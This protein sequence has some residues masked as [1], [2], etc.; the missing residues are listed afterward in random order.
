M[1]TRRT[2]GILAAAIAAFACA[3]PRTASADGHIRSIQVYQDTDTVQRQ[4][5]NTSAP[6]VA[7]DRIKIKIRLVNY[8]LDAVT[9][10]RMN[11]PETDPD[12]IDPASRMWALQHVRYGDP[13]ADTNNM[14][15]VGLWISGQCKYADIESWTLA[16]KYFTDLVCT[17]TVKAGDLAMPLKL[18]R[19]DGLADAMAPSSDA[20]P[21]AASYYGKNFDVWNF[22]PANAEGD[23]RS[24]RVD[25][26]QFYFGPQTLTVPAYA[27]EVRTADQQNQA[28]RDYDL[29][30]AGVYVQGVDF[31]DTT[32]ED[33][34]IWRNVAAGSTSTAPSPPRITIPGGNVDAQYLYVWTKDPTKVEMET[35]ENYLFGDG[36]TRRVTQLLVSP[37]QTDARFA[38]RGL[39]EDAETDIYMAATP[40]NV[41]KAADTLVTNFTWRTIHVSK[42]L[43][44]GIAVTINPDEV[45]AT[46]DYRTPVSAINVSLTQAWTNDEDLVV[47]LKP[48]MADEEART[49]GVDPFDYIGVSTASSGKEGYTKR[50]LEVTIPKGFSSSA[51]NGSVLYIYANRADAY[52]LRGIRFSVDMDATEAKTPG[53]R[54]FFTGTISD[55]TIQIDFGNPGE[56]ALSVISPEDSFEYGH[57]PGNVEFPFTIKIKDAIGELNTPGNY[58]VYWDNT[59]SGSFVPVSNLTAVVRNEYGEL[60]VMRRYVV[61]TASGN[62]Y[63]SKFYVVNSGGA[64]SATRTVLVNVD[65]PKMISYSCD[66]AD[67]IYAEGDTAQISF[68][69]SSPFEENNG[70][71]GYLFIYP[72]D[73]ATSNKVEIT[74][75]NA[76][77]HQTSLTIQPGDTNAL[78]S[79]SI[80]LKDGYAGCTLSFGVEVR[81]SNDNTVDNVISA[82]TGRPVFI[83]VTNALPRATQITM[84]GTAPKIGA[85]GTRTF[86]ASVPSG[87]QRTFKVGIADPGLRYYDFTNDTAYTELTFR[88]NGEVTATHHIYGSP[89]STNILHTFEGSGVCTVTAKVRDK[90]MT[91]DEFDAA[92]EYVANVVVVDAP[93]ISVSPA[94]GDTTFREKSG[95]G[96]INGRINV[97]LNVAPSG[98]PAGSNIT[99]VVEITPNGTFAGALPEI[100][101]SELTFTRSK[102]SDYF[103]FNSLDGT[104]GSE[105]QG[106]HIRAYVKDEAP[107]TIDPTKTWREFYAE[108]MLDVFV[109]NE[110]PKIGPGDS[111]STNEMPA[112]INVPFDIIWQVSDVKADMTNMVV[113]WITDSTT[114]RKENQNVNGTFRRTVQ[115]S[116]AGSHKVTLTVQDKDGGIDMRTWYYYVEPSMGLELR[117][118]NPLASGISDFSKRYTGAVGHGA[119]RVWSTGAANP[120]KIQNFTQSWDFKPANDLEPSIFGFGYKVGDVDNG[121]LGPAGSKDFAI[122]RAGTWYS[123]ASSYPNHYEYVNA[124]GK[125]SFF[126]TWL[127]YNREDRS[128][129]HLSAPDP[130][131][132]NSLG[133][134]RVVMPEYEDDAKSY[135]KTLVEAIFSVER[136]PEDNVGDINQ[137]GIPDIYA[138]GTTWAGGSGASRFFAVIENGDLES[139]GDLVDLSAYNGDE[140]YMPAR[141][142]HGGL[143]ISTEQNWAT[144]GGIFDAYVE[145]RGLHEG[146]NLRADND[147]L[148][149]HVR[150]KWISD[151][152]F[153]EAESNAIARVNNLWVVETDDDGNETRRLPSPTNAT[154]MAAWKAGLEKADSWIPENRTD[155]TVD[156]TDKDG[157]PDGYE[158]Y[159]WYSAMVGEDGLDKRLRGSKF[160]LDD[161]A[162]GVEITPEEIAE[163]FDP[164]KKSGVRYNERDTDDDGLL[165]I[166]ELALCTNPINWD[167]DGDGL[168]DLW[169]VMN[170]MN[171]VKSDNANNASM[172]ADGDFMAYY[173]TPADYMIVKIEGLGEY[174]I[175]NNGGNYVTTDDSGKHVFPEG[176]SNITAIA[177]FRYGKP[178]AVCVP[179]FRGGDGAKPL[180]ATVIAL[181]EHTN[182]LSAAADK[183]LALIHDQVYTQLGFDPRTAWYIDRDGFL[184]NRWHPNS[185]AGASLLNGAGDPVNTR[186]FTAMDEYLLLKYRYEATPAMPGYDPDTGGTFTFSVAADKDLW[187]DKKQDRV[188]R[189]GTTNPNVPFSDPGWVTEAMEGRTFANEAHGADTDGDGVP[190]GWELYVLHNPNDPR[191]VSNADSDSDDLNLIGEYAGTDSCNAYSGCESIANNHPGKN[192]GWYNKFF[193]TDPHDS[194][195]DGD[196]LA[197]GEE[198]GGW[199][200]TWRYG[201]SM[202]VSPYDFTF[203][204]GSNNGKPAED[205]D[206]GVDLCIRGGGL[207]PNTADTDGDLLPDKWERQ[208]AGIVFNESAQPVN[209]TV[210]DEALTLIRRSDGVAIDAT[211]E[212]TV[213]GYYI[214]AGMDGTFAGDAFTMLPD[215]DISVR[216]AFFDTPA[217]DPRTGTVRDFDFDH[218]GLQNFQEYLVQAMRHLRYDDSETPLMG[219]WMPDGPGS[220]KFVGFLPMNIMDGDTFYKTCRERGFAATGAWQFEKLGY[221]TRPPRA[222]DWLSLNF[223]TYGQVNY[224]EQGYRIMLTPTALD[225]NGQRVPAVGYITTDPRVWDTDADGMD[226]YYEIFHGLNPLLGT[227]QDG[228]LEGDVVAEMYNGRL[229]HWYNAWTEWPDEA[230]NGGEPVFDVMSYPWMMGTPEADADGD[231]LRNITEALLVNMTSPQPPHTDPTPLWYTDSTALNDSSLTLQYYRLDPYVDAPD[232]T[233]YPGWSWM[234]GGGMTMEAA[235]AGTF[236]YS[237]EENEGYDTDNDRIADADERTMTST[238]I[239]DPIN[240]TDPDRR[241]ALWFPGADSAAVSYSGYLHRPVGDQYDMLRQFTAEAWILPED[242]SRDQVVLERASRYTSST[243]SNFNYQVRVNFRIGIKADGRVFG[244]FDTSDAVPSGVGIGSPTVVGTVPD[245]GKWVHVALTFDGK[246]LKLYQNGH[247]SARAA[248]SLEPANGIMVINQEAVPGMQNFPVLHGGYTTV[249]TAFILG[250]TAVDELA[251]G[252]GTTNTASWASFDRFYNGYIDEVRVWDG[253][254][255][256]SAILRA[257]SEKTRMRFADVLA[258]RE[259][260]YAAWLQDCT[261]NDNDGKGMLPPELLQHY[262][263]QTLPGAVNATDVMWE[264]SG[265]TK[266]VF[267][268]VRDMDGVLPAGT[269]ECGWWSAL[270]VHS[271]VYENYRW[272]PWIQNTC[273]HLPFMDGTCPDSRYWSV[274]FG[275]VCSA[276]EVYNSRDDNASE[277]EA[278]TAGEVKKIIF[279]NGAQPY[280]LYSYSSE[281]AYSEFFFNY[282]SNL[283]SARFSTNATLNSF[284][285]RSGFVGTSDLVPL[286][287]AFAK[288]CETM[289][290]GDG[291]ADPWEITADG[292]SIFGDLDANGIPDWWQDIAISEY[293][294]EEG[295]DWEST[296][297]YNGF[298]MTAREAYLRDLAAGMLSDGSTDETFLSRRDDDK[299]G[300]PD[301]W[302]NLNGIAT[303][304]SYGDHDN[305]QL[306]NYAEYL[307]SEGFLKYEFPRVSPVKSN[308]FGQGVPDYFLRVG[309][310]YLGQM[311]ADGD[312][313]NDAW[314]DKYTSAFISRGLWDALDDRDDD[315]WS[316]WAEY[317]AGTRPDLEAILGPDNAT[318]SEYPVPVIEAF[319]AYNGKKDFTSAI[320]VQAWS[321]ESRSDRQMTGLP[322]AVWT[323]PGPGEATEKQKIIGQN[324]NREVKFSLGPGSVAAGTVYVRFKDPNALTMWEDEQFGGWV[325]IKSDDPQWWES[326]YDRPVPGDVEHGDIVTWKGDVVGSINYITGVMTINFAHRDL[327]GVNL[328]PLA[329]AGGGNNNDVQLYEFIDLSRANVM[330]AWTAQK[331]NVGKSGKFYL[332][333]SDEN[334]AGGG[335][336]DNGGGSGNDAES[337]GPSSKYGHLREGKNLFVAFAD[338]DGNGKWSPGEPYGIAADVDVGWSSAA[339]SIELT[340]TTPQMARMDISGLTAAEDFAT[341]DLLTDRSAS[342]NGYYTPNQSLNKA[343][344]ILETGEDA[345]N[346][347]TAEEETKPTANATTRVRVVRTA[348]NGDLGVASGGTGSILYNGTVLDREI[349]L[350]GHPTLTEADLVADGLLD[351]DWG[352]LEAVWR[353][354]HNGSAIMT[355]LTNVTYRVMYGA[356]SANYGS[357]PDGKL[358]FRALAAVTFVNVFENSRTQTLAVAVSPKGTTQG[359][360]VTFRWTHEAKDGNGYKLKDYPA[361]RLQVLDQRDTVVYDSGDRR[362][363]VRDSQG[364]YSWTAPLYDG[365]V[366]PEGH[367]FSSKVNYKWR[368]SMLDAKFTTPNW[369][370]Q[371]FR[372]EATGMMNDGRRYGTV[373]ANVRYFGPV[374]ERA[375]ITPSVVRNLIHVDAFTASDFTGQPVASGWVADTA[376]LTSESVEGVN[377]V[378]LAL[379]AGTYY[380]RAY[381]DS[382]GNFERDPWESWGYA[383]S[384]GGSDPDVYKPAPVTITEP[385][386][387]VPQVTIYIEDCD[388]DQDGFPDSWEWAQFG[389]L[390]R[391]SSASGDTF[392]TKVNPALIYSSAITSYSDL[393]LTQLS[394]GGDYVT[395]R[396]MSVL[397]GGDAASVAAAALMSGVD[398][399]DIEPDVSVSID[400]FSAD[401]D[402]SASVESAGRSRG[403]LRLLSA[404]ESNTYRLTLLSA[405][406]LGGEWTETYVGE[407]TVPVN[408]RCELPADRL[409]EALKARKAAGDAF[410]KVKLR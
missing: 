53:A 102:T 253:A 281:R 62:P 8:G 273:A 259:E 226:D 265:F 107:S 50:N 297:T 394:S 13:V 106:F 157:I 84:N 48:E 119:G 282:M 64:Q 201:N 219:S 289:W 343:F 186:A 177:V 338:T 312:M 73:E 37:G 333:W 196:G 162:T 298:E 248:T 51:E 212:V 150:G 176:V 388:T 191:A 344:R 160:T 408:G 274:F 24:N 386:S 204:Y 175:P 214:T 384:I 249:P 3:V 382:N 163:A 283:D 254:L 243:L 378:T 363:P 110:D 39:V 126:Y 358:N 264:P 141:T 122:D 88:E 317:Q 38:V 45:T 325:Y 29:S 209:G 299:D 292:D 189:R 125:D 215:G 183:P 335:D 118:C 83:S 300:M 151:P 235:T 161:I 336:D 332:S 222:W 405:Q 115:F 402:I 310:L 27:N 6:L 112:S 98:L 47:V 20:V 234:A 313:M 306:S 199:V 193:P 72:L 30:R 210:S 244:Q 148:N 207:N 380:L 81:E 251:L 120:T 69:F 351:L 43:P 410:F 40:T 164:T 34:S 33:A 387:A 108:G 42:S 272:V 301:W 237:F 182:I 381:I 231:G 397:L 7:G 131:F 187:H 168:S 113:T 49:A 258:Q 396:L 280:T 172:N 137:D 74:S 316:N 362:A 15:Q 311:F 329:D 295:F 406:T 147:G 167:T 220:R 180:D 277:L 18:V 354:T 356:G 218:D 326:V 134:G 184:G 392:F 399:S 54:A 205:A 10:S 284:D 294:A 389:S 293:G 89:S 376:D 349:Y 200:G 320:V 262:N 80:L 96:T 328:Q 91:D 117:P 303:E 256:A 129:A 287:G 270:P 171:P 133:E 390:D 360:S 25:R 58:T 185:S 375:S 361:F 19:P 181:G 32:T 105:S 304:N 285:T 71:A 12:Y 198:G 327:Q 159:F 55:D 323:I 286:G 203:I 385:S 139:A 245:E 143:L 192:S 174:A 288:R 4:Y 238:A 44:P 41:Y 11:L 140:D 321:Q 257:Y 90:D 305:D 314:E 146:I 383:N 302:E 63:K 355:A 230:W 35:G 213:P 359:S 334:A 195:T 404:V 353:E 409:G 315:G 276:R 79:A 247:V 291:A 346:A 9:V 236:I 225:P 261:R 365:M 330:I 116:G 99:V 1:N 395:P 352:T 407:V 154:E 66:K 67:G 393:G 14:P 372:L 296:V 337:S 124:L 211:T 223:Y 57:I 339:F 158:Y 324:R 370:T 347:V 290:D 127:L 86:E 206:N 239:A 17:Y 165:D 403:G 307:I 190:D 252:I 275:G 179:K 123:T 246:E 308:T 173:E 216:G 111:V 232:L 97:D 36:I 229:A 156:D 149:R 155:P 28:Y 266:Y 26:L 76:L 152:I 364:I 263:F 94:L 61:A 166:E 78:P 52:T 233:V 130:Q 221:F 145:L 331:L 5:P 341:A 208:Y 82:W 366:T 144:R 228:T 240:F 169:E 178:D 269:F 128:S 114:D 138:A 95:T 121:S 93:A 391:Q 400:G 318:L 85:D 188:L 59:G 401:G 217:T 367:V 242:L 319:V 268:N 87:V 135:V 77:T 224:D 103:F 379:P 56:G 202:S 132:N 109:V 68:S 92:P 227:V 46:D 153:S 104:P 340:D 70:L 23:F 309:S 22:F 398:V 250:A 271:T 16:D 136:F 373:A 350:G 194:D 279:P 368:V 21:Y 241:Q 75:Q 377:A 357:G 369:T 278:M 101:R 371:D 197:D 2:L 142:A 374:A 100:N 170:G 31:D 342:V 60:T 348:V 345:E 322:D 260:V 267:D 65:A 255:D